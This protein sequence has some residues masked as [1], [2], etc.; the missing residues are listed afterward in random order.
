MIPLQFKRLFCYVS[1]GLLDRIWKPNSIRHPFE[2]VSMFLTCLWYMSLK[3]FV[4]TLLYYG[5][6]WSSVWLLDW[7]D[8][9]CLLLAW[10]LHCYVYYTNCLKIKQHRYIFLTILL[11]VLK[12]EKRLKFFV[13]LLTNFGHLDLCLYLLL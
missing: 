8:Y 11:N 10:L 2:V 7:S 4:S 9:C 6:L 12:P 1:F 13:Y 3:S 5:S